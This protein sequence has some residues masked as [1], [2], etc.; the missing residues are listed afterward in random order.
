M[1]VC[2][3]CETTWF[4]H[5]DTTTPSSESS[6]AR[7]DCDC[8]SGKLWQPSEEV[9]KRLVTGHEPKA[10][11]GTPPVFASVADIPDDLF[12]DTI[13]FILNQKCR[14]N[15]SKDDLDLS[16]LPSPTEPAAMFFSPCRQTK[17]T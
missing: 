11:P 15:H 12:A 14:Q 1:S 13:A 5:V 2:C 3:P 8:L 17:F 16:D 6:C 4:E 10:T 9:E 7:S